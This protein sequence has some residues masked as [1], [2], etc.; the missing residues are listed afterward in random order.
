MRQATAQRGNS[1]REG[2][3]IG[4]SFNEKIRGVEMAFE[5]LD[6]LARLATGNR[7]RNC[8]NNIN[9]LLLRSRREQNRKQDKI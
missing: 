7:E 4:Q 9:R 3:F 5:M 2:K 6:W 1:E 8:T